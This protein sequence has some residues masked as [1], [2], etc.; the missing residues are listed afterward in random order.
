MSSRAH[1]TKCPVGASAGRTKPKLWTRAKKA[2][3]A[4]FE[5]PSARAWQWAAKWYVK[6]GGRYC[7][8]KTKAQQAMSKWTRE[9]WTTASGA[10]ACRGK[11]SQRR[12][13]RY[14]PKAA[15]KNLSPAQQRATRAKKLKASRQFVKNTKAA[16]RAGKA[17]RR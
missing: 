14:L 3:L 6:N 9:K 8:K 13:D 1:L 5:K 11:G 17:A 12:C 15:W 16:A 2:A 7:G 10:K 4:K